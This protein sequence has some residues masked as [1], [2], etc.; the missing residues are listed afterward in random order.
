MSEKPELPDP[1][2][3]LELGSAFAASRVL[4]TAIE[5]DLFTLLSRSPLTASEIAEKLGLHPRAVPDFPDTLLALDVITREGDGPEARYANSELSAH[6]LVKGSPAYRGDFFEMCGKRLY[7]FW[8]H[9]TE[10]LQTGRRQNEGH[11]RSGGKELWEGIYEN[12]EKLKGFIAA[13]SANNTAAHRVFAKT[14]DWT[15]VSTHLDVGGASGQLSCEVAKANPGVRSTTFDLERVSRIAM[16]NIEAQALSG[17]V[18]VMPGSFWEDWKC[19]KVDVVTMGQILHDY[20]LPKKM[21][22]LKKAYEALNQGGRFVALEL[23]IEDDR[24]GS[25][26]ALLMSLN[27]IVETGLGFDFSVKEFDVWAKKVGFTRTERLELLPP[28]GAVVAY[29]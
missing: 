14:F 26:P 27:M 1:T 7:I 22:L 6:Y 18:E 9:L 8:G 5:L 25:V 23:L 28:M 3:I 29:K 17:K 13:M 20:S 2:P 21:E 24:R 16:R 12:D 4:L 19:A 10:A 11:P 15:N